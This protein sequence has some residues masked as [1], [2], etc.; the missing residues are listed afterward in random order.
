MRR[1]VLF[2][3]ILILVGI[4][5]DEACGGENVW[6]SVFMPGWGQ[7]R[8]GHYGRASMFIGAEIVSLTA[9][10]VTDIQYNRAVD[11]YERAKV[12]YE[13]ATYMGDAVS[14]Y[15]SMREHWD[16]ADDFY[17]YRRTALYAAI[18]VWAVNVVDM[19][20]SDEK[21]VPPLSLSLRPGGFLVSGSISF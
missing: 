7:V 2:S 13:Q 3:I 10:V 19:I 20:L 21:D 11:Q 15:Y 9:L 17:G 1:V 8:A 4:M 16:S 6:C 12:Y 5:S 18:G 14:E